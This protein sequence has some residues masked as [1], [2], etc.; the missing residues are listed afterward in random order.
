MVAFTTFKEILVTVDLL[1][2]PK[3]KVKVQSMKVWRK[4]SETLSEQSLI[5]LVPQQNI[6]CKRVLLEAIGS[7]S[8]VVC[9]ERQNEAKIWINMNEKWIV[10]A[11]LNY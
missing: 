3:T 4:E 5:Q 7:A 8:F 11:L 2:D 6:D 10:Q 9:S 1:D